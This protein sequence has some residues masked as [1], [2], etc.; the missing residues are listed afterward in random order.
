M[1]Q[2]DNH[3]SNMYLCE[4]S[5]YLENLDTQ[6]FLIPAIENIPVTLSLSSGKQ[7]R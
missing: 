2:L 6:D 3:T 4:S 7:D 1:N 5:E